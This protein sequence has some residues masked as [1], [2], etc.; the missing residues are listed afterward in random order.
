MR[1]IDPPRAPLG[2]SDVH[3]FVASTEDVRSPEDV[4]EHRSIL[5]ESERQRCDRF[6]FAKDRALYLVA[7]ALVRSALSCYAN[8][9]P[10]AWRFVQNAFGR[11]EIA[12]GFTNRPIRFSLSHSSGVAIVAV[13][14]DRDIG[15]DVEEI[16]TGTIVDDVTSYAFSARE[17]SAIAAMRDPARCRRFFEHWTLKEAYIKAIGTGLSTPPDRVEFTWSAGAPRAIFDRRLKDDERAWTFIQWTPT[18]RHTAAI[19]V[20]AR[21]SVGV[22]LSICTSPGATRLEQSLEQGLERSVA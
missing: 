1:L 10:G 3:V 2:P 12:R 17:R 15:A 21:R 14:C 6:L 5:C 9:A 4:A 22:R 16:R 8:V 13:A 20:R 11:P 19:A 18:A 7:H